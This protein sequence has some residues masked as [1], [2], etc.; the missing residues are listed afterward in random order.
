MQGA[1]PI[2]AGSKA[3]SRR[4]CLPRGGPEACVVVGHDALTGA[5]VW[6]RRLVPAPGEPGD[7]SWG[8]VAFEERT[9]VGAWMA[10]SYDPALDLIYVGTPV[11]SPAP[12]FM[13]GGVDLQPPLPQ[14][15][16]GPQRRRR[17]DPLVLPAPERPLGPRPSLRAHPRRHRGCPRPLAGEL[18]QP[19]PAGDVVSSLTITLR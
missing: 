3:V 2:V 8:G 7:E 9:H 4:S 18:D 6:R 11:T 1:E 14:L 10:S 12:K 19:A 5:E 15:D 16:A 13:L 17:R